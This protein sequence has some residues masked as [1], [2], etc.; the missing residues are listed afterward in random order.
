MKR[1]EMKSR[2]EKSFVKKIISLAQELGT[3]TIEINKMSE[4]AIM[5]DLPYSDAFVFAAHKFNRSNHGYIKKY[6]SKIII[7]VIPF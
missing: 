2:Y 6:G 7:E 1:D 3:Y 5:M 4:L